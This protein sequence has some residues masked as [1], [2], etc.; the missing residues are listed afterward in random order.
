M[1]N[2]HGARSTA[3]V[4]LGLASVLTAS[5]VYASAPQADSIDDLIAGMGAAERRLLN[6]HIESAEMWAQEQP[7]GSSEWKPTPLGAKVEGWYNGKRASKARLEVQE[8]V[9]PWEQGASPYVSEAMSIGFDGQYGRLAMHTSGPPGTKGP[10]KEGRVTPEAPAY[11]S[12]LEF[13]VCTGTALSL[14]MWDDRVEQ[15][16]LSDKL[17]RWMAAAQKGILSLEISTDQKATGPCVKITARAPGRAD[18]TC[19]VDPAKGYA[20]VAYEWVGYRKDGTKYVVDSREVTKIE[21]IAP[22]IWYPIEGSLTLN[23]SPTTGGPGALRRM[24][25]R[26]HKAV[27]NDPHF[28]ESVFQVHFPPEYTVVDQVLGVSYVVSQPIPQL[29]SSLDDLASVVAAA[30]TRPEVLPRSGALS[31]QASRG[32]A[33][34]PAVPAIV[35]LSRSW[36]WG[37]IIILVALS[38]LLVLR[39]SRRGV[40]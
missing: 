18:E 12:T 28:D 27:A 33:T 29:E 30:A 19:W 20:P 35:S 37:G 36:V 34:A 22:G 23:A 1:W 26:V 21:E 39:R 8:F 40:Q 3:G 6:L 2:A 9:S 11:M 31:S 5:V 4:L 38:L 7:Q 14:Y 16:P 25:F 32:A 17:R 13:A 15:K 24:S 10:V